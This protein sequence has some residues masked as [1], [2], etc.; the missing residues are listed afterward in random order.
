M[1]A[2]MMTLGQAHALLAAAMPDARLVG[3]ASLALR[4]IHSDTRSLAAG[5][6]FVALRGERHDAHDFLS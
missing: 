2:P 5:D 4:R 6:F 1:S 3:D